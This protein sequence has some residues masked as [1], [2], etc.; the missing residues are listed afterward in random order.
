MY[1]VA[2]VGF[3]HEPDLPLCKQKVYIKSDKR[4]SD[5]NYFNLM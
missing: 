2:G 1:K 3:L 5:N 4:L